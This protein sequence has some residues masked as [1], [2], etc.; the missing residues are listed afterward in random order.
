MKNTTISLLKARKG[1]GIPLP[2]FFIVCMVCVVPTVFSISNIDF[3]NKVFSSSE[4]NTFKEI[5]PSTPQVFNYILVLFS[6]STGIFIGILSLIDFKVKK[7]IS[8]PIIGLTLL[9]IAV[10]DMLHLLIATGIINLGIR[11]NDA[12]YLTWAIPRILTALF[13]IVGTGLILMIRWKWRKRR[14]L[15]ITLFKF[16]S[17]FYFTAT[18]SSLI[19]IFHIDQLPGTF[20]KTSGFIQRPLEFLTVVLFFIW[21]FLI[22]PKAIKIL[23]SIFSQFLILSMVPA[24]FA[25]IHMSVSIEPFDIDFT[26]AQ[27]LKL[28]AFII[29][30]TGLSLNYARNINKQH[31]INLNLDKEV[32]RMERRQKNLESKQNLLKHAEAIANMGSWEL[33]MSNNEMNWSDSLYKIFGYSPHSTKPNLTIMLDMVI[34]E[35]KDELK[36]TIY[37]SVNSPHSFLMEYQIKTV[38]GNIRYIQGQGQFIEENKKI[39]G[40]CLDITDLKETTVKLKHN[41][42]L[43]KEAESISHNGSFE[44]NNSNDDIFWSDE[45]YRIH[46][47]S[48]NSL[49]IDL[50]LYRTLIHPDDL[51]RCENTITKALSTNRNFVIEYRVVRPNQ[52]IRFL[53][54]NVRIIKDKSKDSLKIL[55]TLQDITDLKNTA[56]LIEKTE[57]I[58]K[59]IAKNVP[60][61][62]VMMYDKD[63]NLML[64]DGPIINNFDF[65]SDPEI[66]INAVELYEAENYQNIQQYL[67][68]ALDGEEIQLNEKIN[69]NYYKINY[70][71]V[72]NITEEI[73]SV[74][75]VVQDIS[76]I[77]A[78]HQDLEFKVEELNRSNQDLEQFAYVA[79]HDLQ[80]P[81]RKIKAF[82]DRL[83]NKFNSELPEEGLDYIRRMQYASER[84]QI[85]IDDLLTYSRVTRLDEGYEKVDLHQQ[86]QKVLED[87]EF[88]IGKKE[89]T[90]NLMINHHIVAAPGQIRQLFQNLISN[91]I[92]FNKENVAPVVEIRSEILKGNLLNFDGL[93][94]D[95]DY[96]QIT[97]KDNG[98]GIDEQYSDKIFSLFQRLHTRN[99]YQ[100]TGIGLAVCKK[101]VER[102]N[103]QIKV[104]SQPGQGTLFKIIFPLV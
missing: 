1:L 3:S 70:V 27:F 76:A 79:S 24:I 77:K 72:K 45:L 75:M 12:I 36:N 8:A 61:S 23:P 28:F 74:M 54:G 99:E 34:P 93:N 86:I 17:L 58:Y 90:I 88:T 68:R 32:R 101:I 44:W 5:Y 96:C 91:A 104:M 15:K 43:L 56:I 82:G 78:A 9:S 4:N 69:D 18:L 7:D 20:L 57:S 83:Q 52:E 14:E 35:F 40:T 59:T 31:E 81:L 41:E 48:P 50:G 19:F 51:Q 53:Y 16:L 95:K 10:L 62:A 39:I 37:N 64:F 2:Y 98:I 71:P 85:L 21:G 67:E 42:A 65:K 25:A 46:G 97:V 55:G 47:F 66:G 100:G 63:Y 29:P 49:K 103:G 60:D 94:P 6:I 87:L 80:E 84:M 30:L 73:F 11:F 102:H 26:V 33:Q 92:K 13:L 89:A 38:E 22:L